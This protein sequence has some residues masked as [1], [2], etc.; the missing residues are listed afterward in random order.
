MWPRRARGRRASGQLGT[1]PESPGAGSPPPGRPGGWRRGD[2]QAPVADRSAGTRSE[3]LSF[4]LCPGMLRNGSEVWISEGV[5]IDVR[6]KGF[7]LPRLNRC[8]DSG[9]REAEEEGH[10]VPW[11]R[12]RL[13][14]GRHA[15]TSTGHRAASMEHAGSY[16]KVPEDSVLPHVGWCVIPRS[17]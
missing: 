10:Q 13:R 1:R 3:S 11:R 2:S 14:K 12:E 6:P 4:D 9:S 8:N 17:S 16:R 7:D 15:Q 5:G